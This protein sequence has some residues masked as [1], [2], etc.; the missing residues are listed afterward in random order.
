MKKI[1]A[2]FVAV[3]SVALWSIPASADEAPARRRAAARPAA[4]P[5]P[6]PVQTTN[7]SGGQMGSSNGVSSVNNNF[8]EPGSYN[9]FLAPGLFFSCQ[10]TPFSISD[11]RT[12]FI[13]GV[14][15]GYRWQM[16]M[17]VVGVEGD[18]NY[19]FN[20]TTTNYQNTPP[21]WLA[22]EEF[23]GSAKQTWDGSARGRLG[24]LVNQNTL[25]YATGGVAFG[26]SKGSYSYKGC[27]FVTFVGSPA[28]VTG[29]GSWSDTRVGYTV[30]G[31]VEAAISYGWKARVEY[32]YTDLGSYSANVPLSNNYGGLCGNLCG[33]NARLDLQP[34]N[35]RITFGI[36]FDF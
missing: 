20:S 36:G 24:F 29:A 35:Q 28:C 5:A 1:A 12:G 9:C 16:G 14:Y 31:G 2:L 8:V 3:A 22:S 19:K 23:Y 4:A 25:L 27:E 26:E 18:A 34:T 32:R 11:S 33:S 17:W 30:G 7:W 15:L 6:A 21:P 10:E 13:T